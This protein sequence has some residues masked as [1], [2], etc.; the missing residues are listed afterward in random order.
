MIPDS[1]PN[2]AMLQSYASPLT[3][4]SVGSENPVGSLCPYLIES[5]QP[6]LGALATFCDW[7]FGWEG[8]AIITKMCVTVWEGATVQLMCG[9]LK[10]PGD[11]AIFKL[12]FKQFAD[13]VWAVLTPI[14]DHQQVGWIR[15]RRA[16]ISDPSSLCR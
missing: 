3:T 9:L 7:H 1:F 12:V 10:Q 16:C 5:Q 13:A 15:G 2:P 6:D 14:R 8:D 4:F 11:H